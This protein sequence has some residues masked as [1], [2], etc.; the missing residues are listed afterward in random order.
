MRPTQWPAFLA[1]IQEHGIV[2]PIEITKAGVVLDGRHRLR[3]AQTLN[4]PRVPVRVVAPTDEVGYILR[5]GLQRRQLSPS[6]V[7]AVVVSLDEYQRT[8]DASRTRQRANLRAPRRVEAEPLPPP[9]ETLAALA[10]RYGVSERLLRDAHTIRTLA[11]DQLA[12]VAAGHIP[13]HRL[14]NRLHQHHRNQAL[15][16]PPLPQGRFDVILAD[17]PW[18]LGNPQSDF[19]AEQHYPTLPLTDIT[20]IHVPAATDAILF[21]WAVSGLLPEALEVVSAWGFTYK[22]NGVWVKNAIGPGVWLR[23]RHELLLTATRGA[24]T[25][26]APESRVDSVITAKRRR[27]SQKPD[28]AY[29]RIEAM[30][31]VARRLELFAR[32]T[33]PGWTSWGNQLTQGE[34]TAA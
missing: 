19:S 34:E 29:E 8:L 12:A 23:N 20:A 28:E 5:K 24:W 17:P 15:Q 14:A 7:A 13:A 18:Q 33:R 9:G 3:A 11:P 2:E 26:P 10:A 32:T 4:L 21:L 30:Y 27:H 1:D 31:P 6:Q 22:T 25:P 16:T